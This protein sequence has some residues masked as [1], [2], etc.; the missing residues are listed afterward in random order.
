MGSTDPAVVVGY[1]LLC[2]GVGALIVTIPVWVPVIWDAMERGADRLAGFLGELL[3]GGW[4]GLFA[5][6][7][8]VGPDPAPLPNLEVV[9]TES[10]KNWVTVEVRGLKVW[11][12]LAHELACYA[13]A[14]H[15]NVPH[16]FMEVLDTVH[17]PGK[18]TVRVT[19]GPGRTAG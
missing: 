2:L 12:S 19:A 16:I 18:T 8:R 11:P 6:G 15:T 14:E 5:R 9:I 10:M 13:A 1:T 17:A 7:G 3:G 4:R